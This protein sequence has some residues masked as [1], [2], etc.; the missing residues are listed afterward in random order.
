MQVKN[1]KTVVFKQMRNGPEGFAF[2]VYYKRKIVA[3]TVNKNWA[4]LLT[5][6]MKLENQLSDIKAISLLVSFLKRYD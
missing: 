2:A 3:L 1:N 4:M 6:A 5:W